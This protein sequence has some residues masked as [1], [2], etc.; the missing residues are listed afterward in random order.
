[1]SV[2]LSARFN[3]GSAVALKRLVIL[4]LS[5]THLILFRCR[6]PKNESLYIASNEP[7]LCFFNPLSEKYGFK[8]WTYHNFLGALDLVVDNDYQLFAMEMEV[9]K[10]ARL[11]IATFKEDSPSHYLSSHARWPSG[12]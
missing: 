8:I 1:M 9:V 3:W 7:E 4:I 5:N 6:V 12:Q 11:K 10:H 2:A